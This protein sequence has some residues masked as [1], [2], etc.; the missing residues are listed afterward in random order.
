MKIT[1]RGWLAGSAAAA[2]SPALAKADD[3]LKVL[4]L[5]TTASTPFYYALHEGLFTKA[6]L[7]VP[8]HV[9]GTYRARLLL[10]DKAALD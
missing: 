8:M 2:V 1:R 3:P 7:D 5:P 10:S 4:V 6:G 9:N